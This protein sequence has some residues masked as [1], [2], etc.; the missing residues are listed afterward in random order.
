MVGRDFSCPYRLVSHWS[1]W[2]KEGVKNGK[3]SLALELS[4]TES[5]A[6]A[7]VLRLHSPTA[8]YLAPGS[9]SLWIINPTSPICWGYCNGTFWGAHFF[10]PFCHGKKCYLHAF[11]LWKGNLIWR[12]LDS[13]SPTGCSD[14]RSRYLETVTVSIC[15]VSLWGWEQW[16]VAAQQSRRCL[17]SLVRWWWGEKLS[18]KRCSLIY[19]L[20][21]AEDLQSRK[22][23]K[24]WGCRKCSLFSCQ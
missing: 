4:S 21:V 5:I 13:Q 8:V 16:L 10:F 7:A 23:S 18:W 15:L 22:R 1:F 17:L 19:G 9:S 2:N 14:S 12:I 6:E 3:Y 11:S 20:Q 24:C